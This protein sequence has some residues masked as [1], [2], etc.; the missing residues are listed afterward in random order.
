MGLTLVTAIAS[1][2]HF[3]AP[4]GSWSEVFQRRVGQQRALIHRRSADC[5]ARLDRLAEQLLDQ[6]DR[7]H[8]APKRD[9]STVLG[10]LEQLEKELEAQR[11][12]LQDR[13][14]EVE[15]QQAVLHEQLQR[16]IDEAAENTR[17]KDRYQRLTSEL[18]REWELVTHERSRTQ[19]Q[20]Q[21]LADEAR[22]QR[23]SRTSSHDLEALRGKVRQVTSERDQ[24][25]EQV[26]DLERQLAEVREAAEESSLHGHAD[27]GELV[28][29]RGKYEL[30][31]TD[32]KE[33]RRR[34]ADL[35]N[36]RAH[37][38]PA[39]ESA[40]LDWESRKRQMLAEFEAEERGG[41]ITPER[42][43]DRLTIEGTIL[44][45][46]QMIQERDNEIAELKRMLDEQSQNV[47]QLAVG[48]AA[49]G[50]LFETDEIIAQQRQHMQELEGELQQKLRTAEIEISRERAKLAR[51]RA[52]IDELRRDLDNQRPIAPA[53]STP[54]KKPQPGGNWLARLGL[55]ADDA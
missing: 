46:D 19:L 22:Q 35:E 41:S 54:G 20:R 49:I 12:H 14:Q 25:R 7:P 16:T 32:L 55:K 36:A 53:D 30:A 10:A 13:E 33:L 15:R 42:V 47:G 18:E 27:A 26:Q 2:H 45:T 51:D 37:N 8:I 43:D 28:T 48:A 1:E 31:M 39:T 17:S 5:R 24:L 38:A 34:N 40:P 52:E 6:L 23:Q 3:A 50:Q 4:S 21:R 44:I 29:L 9:E 11:S